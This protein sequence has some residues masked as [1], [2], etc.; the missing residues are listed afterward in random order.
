MIP[1]VQTSTP[2]SNP[3]PRGGVWLSLAIVAMASLGCD[4]PATIRSGDIRSYELPRAREPLVAR[5]RQPA[6]G[7]GRLAYEPPPGWQDRGGSGIRLA[8]LVIEDGE[9]GHEVTVISASGTLQANVDRWLGQ[10][11]PSLAEADRG[12]LAAEAVE[13]AETVT[14]GE[15]EATVVLLAD[16][17]A[18]GEQK[19]E[20]AAREAI[21][22]A[23]IP[24]DG[25]EALF[26][27]FK[28]PAEVA[29]R[30]RAAFTRFVSSIRWN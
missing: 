18:P 3:E 6:R 23:M 14:A 17:A 27:K 25:S 15:R 2:F 20:D 7:S 29:R 30:E 4:D 1:A 12:R 8:T 11:A 9:R 13:A 21:L 24:L 5:P 28:G 10:L 26:V 16:A 19:Q 22:A